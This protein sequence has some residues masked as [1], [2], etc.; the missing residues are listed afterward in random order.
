MKEELGLT[1]QVYSSLGVLFVFIDIEPLCQQ[2]K[3]NRDTVST[4]KNPC[5][6]REFLCRHRKYSR[7]VSHSEVIMKHCHCV[8]SGKLLRPHDNLFL[9]FF[10]L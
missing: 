6:L 10:R 5:V 3:V 4:Q 9:H 1:D 7:C 8:Y 2:S